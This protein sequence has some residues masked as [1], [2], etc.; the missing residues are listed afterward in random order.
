[1]L[2]LLLNMSR[3]STRLSVNLRISLLRSLLSICLLCI[4][5]LRVSLLRVSLSLVNN[6]GVSL[7]LRSLLLRSVGLNG[8]SLLVVLTYGLLGNLSFLLSSSGLSCVILSSGDHLFDIV[9]RQFPD[10]RL[11]TF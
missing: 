3:D 10:C 2:R 4:N 11:I 7:L 6:L 5:R 9:H 1:M 8:V